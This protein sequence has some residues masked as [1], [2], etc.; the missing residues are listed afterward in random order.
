M[1][2]IRCVVH[3]LRVASRTFERELGLSAAQ[4]FV[5]RKLANS[6][7]L[8]LNELAQRTLTH[9]SSVS[10]VV[11][12]LVKAGMVLTSPSPID[13]RRVEL[14]LTAKGRRTIAKSPEMMQDKLIEALENMPGDSRRRLAEL[15][16]DLVG[17]AGIAEEFPALLM[18]DGQGSSNGEEKQ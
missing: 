17:R 13:G 5:L 16:Q 1:D 11:Q 4:L 15:L 7:A 14:A 12:K 8:S 9:Q 6:K 2:A 10:V 18:E 3:A